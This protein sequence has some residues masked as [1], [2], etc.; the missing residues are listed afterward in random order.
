MIWKGELQTLPGRV[1]FQDG[2]GRGGW[3]DRLESA[4]DGA[5]LGLKGQF[6]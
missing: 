2:C 1:D 6:E 3:K 4:S 5:L